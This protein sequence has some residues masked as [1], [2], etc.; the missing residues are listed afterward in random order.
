LLRQHWSWTE[1]VLLHELAHVGRHVLNPKWG[2]EAAHSTDWAGL[3]LALLGEFIGPASADALR[4]AF[5]AH[6]VRWA[7]V[8]A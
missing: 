1:G 3:Y 8:T 4:G 5:R 6:R 2:T 7:E